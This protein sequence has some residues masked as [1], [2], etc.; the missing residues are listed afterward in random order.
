[1]IIIQI[2]L[3]I[4]FI[5][6]LIRFLA[7]PN[8]YQVRAW[9]KIMGILFT[10]MAVSVVLFP[11]M[12]NRLAH[13]VGVGRGADLLLY[14][15]TLSFIFLSINLYL[16][17]KQEQRRIVQLARKIAILEAQIQKK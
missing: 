7:N 4:G 5:Y 1:M 12:S 15:L 3:I 14:L 9:K 17:S 6:G 11:D 16:K 8:S 2:I 13:A 10:L